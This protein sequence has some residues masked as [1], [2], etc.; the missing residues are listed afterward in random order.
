MVKLEAKKLDPLRYN[1]TKMLS[2][3][4]MLSFVISTRSYG[5]SFAL[6]YYVVN[7]AIKYGEKF[8]HLRRTK[9]DIKENMLTYFSDLKA[10]FPEHTFV[11]KGNKLYCDGDLIGYGMALSNWQSIKSSAYPDVTTM[12]YDEFMKEK[13][14]TTYLP[15]EPRALLNLLHTIGRDR[16]DFRCV[17]LSNSTSVTNPYFLYFDL[18]LTKHKSENKYKRFNTFPKR[19]DILIEMPD[20]KDYIESV[21]KTS[22]F[23]RLIQGTDYAE[24]AVNNEFTDDDPSFIEKKSEGAKYKFSIIIGNTTF[25][26]WLDMRESK[27]YVSYKHDPTSKL[28]FA[29]TTSDMRD[30][31]Y[32][33]NNWKKNSWVSEMVKALQQGYLFYENQTVKN[34]HMEVFKKM[35]IR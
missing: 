32:L 18:Q 2:Y 33:L 1:P 17:C 24:M 23:Q 35:N 22:R 9:K 5:K 12:V 7:R 14:F 3:N 19:P 30:N 10:F 4:R 34:T 6:K 20:A 25:G 13:D 15:N 31:T 29:M 26:Y 11:S 21:K 8:I 27:L 16:E 28:I